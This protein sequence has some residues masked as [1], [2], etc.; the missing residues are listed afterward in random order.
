MEILTFVG[1]VI[2]GAIL[3][4]L[5]QC[6]RTAYGSIDV[7]DVTKICRIS[8]DSSDL[9]NRKIKRAL[10]VVKHDATI[11]QEKQSL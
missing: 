5:Y 8:I 2:L 10:F 4:F 11:S 1:G 6:F 9:A 3:M 7:D